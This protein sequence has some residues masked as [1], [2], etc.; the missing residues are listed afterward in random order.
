MSYLILPIVS[1]R[2]TWLTRANLG[3]TVRMPLS[4]A[5][6]MPPAFD[7]SKA[8]IIREIKVWKTFETQAHL[9]CN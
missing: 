1:S 5:L 9:P 7:E 2:T 3:L 6:L 8:A 4:V